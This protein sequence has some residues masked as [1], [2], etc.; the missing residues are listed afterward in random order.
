MVPIQ[1]DMAHKLPRTTSCY[2]SSENIPQRSDKQTCL[3]VSGQHDCSSIHQQ[4]QGH[5]ITPSNRLCKRPL[6]VVPGEGHYS[7]STTPTREAECDRQS[8][9]KGDE[10]PIRLDAKSKDIPENPGDNGSYGGG[11][12]CILDNKSTALVLQL[13][14]RHSGRSNRCIH[15]GLDK[16]KGLC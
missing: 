14:T 9:V 11:P 12:I 3:F 8:G 15:P 7:I 1:E 5:S 2:T 10:R 16:S 4:P 6:D 13:E